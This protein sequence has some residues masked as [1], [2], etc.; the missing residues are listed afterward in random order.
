MR[1]RVR[2]FVAA[3]LPGERLRE[4]VYA[5][6]R[7]RSSQLHCRFSHFVV[8]EPGPARV[9]RVV[10]PPPAAAHLVLSL[11]LSPPLSH[12]RIF[13]VVHYYYF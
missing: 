4:S 13:Y 2:A 3:A 1:S 11:S 12:S 9:D 6:A 7:A 5:R 8:G 10:V